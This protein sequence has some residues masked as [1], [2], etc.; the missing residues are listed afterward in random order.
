M[1]QTKWSPLLVS[2][3]MIGVFAITGCE[4]KLDTDQRKASYAIGQQIGM[5]LK[6][7]NID[8]DPD[9]IAMSMKDV[10]GAK[11]S[12][13][14][15]E[16]MQ[17]ALKKLQENVNK[18]QMEVANGNLEEAKKFLDANK[19]KDGIKTTASGLQYSVVSEGNGKTPGP[20]DEVKAHYTGTLTNG[21]K[22]DSSVDRGQPA[23]FPVGGVIKGWT[24]ALQ[25]M[26]V[27]GKIK[28]FVPP[29]LGYGSNPR[30]GIPANSVLVFDIELLDT[31]PMAKGGA[32]GGDM[33]G[34]GKKSAKAP[35]ADKEEGSYKE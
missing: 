2:L 13:L 32:P 33:K 26:K 6:N 5:N 15:P 16:E 35:K 12:R 20:N 22:F 17:D 19:S 9:V 10:T 21:T 30:P 4:K 24:E 3:S 25:L 34:P 11:P 29:E 14:K 27:G 1:M 18:K 28:L 31:H 23:T 7:Q 8:F